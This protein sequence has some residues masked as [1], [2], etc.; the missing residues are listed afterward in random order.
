MV[1]GDPNAGSAKPRKKDGKICEEETKT[2]WQRSR[3]RMT[4]LRFSEL[5]L[6]KRWREQS[7]PPP[8]RDHAQT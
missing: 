4:I 1:N 8:W 6:K 3:I 7:A 5:R 2:R